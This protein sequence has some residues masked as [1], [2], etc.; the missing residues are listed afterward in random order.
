MVNFNVLAISMHVKFKGVNPLHIIMYSQLKI[1]TPTEMSPV[2]R[3]FSGHL[4]AK[5]YQTTNLSLAIAYIKT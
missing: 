3:D 5:M 4:L 2:H 1:G